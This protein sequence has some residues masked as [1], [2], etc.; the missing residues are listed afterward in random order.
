MRKVLV[1]LL[2]TTASAMAINKG[3]T[4]PD[5]TL[6]EYQGSDFTLSE[7]RDKVVYIFFLG[8]G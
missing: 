7:H 3:E 4:A 1:L 6:Q 2:F 8:W 5:F